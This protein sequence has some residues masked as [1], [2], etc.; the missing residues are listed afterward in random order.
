MKSG[1]RR[2]AHCP[3][4]RAALPRDE[5]AFATHQQTAHYLTWKAAV[6]PMM[7]VPRTAEKLQSLH[8]EPWV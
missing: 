6:G 5:A 8:P 3:R 4:A 2:A 7:A 1:R